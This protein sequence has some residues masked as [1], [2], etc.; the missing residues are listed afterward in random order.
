MTEL[1]DSIIA[2]T[3]QFDVKTGDTAANLASAVDGIDRLAK[4]G[5]QVAV[6]P[7][8]WPCGFADLKNIRKHAEKTPHI[9]ETLGL[10]AKK[11]QM[12]I[13]GSLPEHSGGHIYN[14]ML[15]IDRDGGIAGTYRKI[16]LFSL[17]NEDKTFTAGSRAV[18]CETSCGPFGL[19]VCYDLRFPELCRTLALQGAR[20]V[21]IS[22][23]WPESRIAHW[24][25]LLCARAIENQLFV[26]AANRVGKDGS[27]SF[28]GHS[29][30]IS[31][32]GR[33]LSI[34]INKT[35]ETTARID[36]SETTAIRNRFD[37][38]NVRK[39]EIYFI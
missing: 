10:L 35:A 7:E 28:S 3:L 2:G 18:I 30:I 32:D 14:T 27:L 37:C 29:Q 24:N 6:L 39:P 17:I 9:I 36:F 38:L 21:V 8:L 20:M 13:A 12:I 15:V 31:P 23:Q 19:M 26:V 33:V 1:P 4:K 25:T 16:H 22:A 11:H 5:A 34:V